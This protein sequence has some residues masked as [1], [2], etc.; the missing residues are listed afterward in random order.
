MHSNAH[1]D[2]TTVVI[3][4]GLAL[5]VLLCAAAGALVWTLGW[6]GAGD[7]VVSPVFLGGVLVAVTLAVRFIVRQ[8]PSR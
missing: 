3:A 8:Q 2:E 4:S 5:F 7:D 1:R 6:L